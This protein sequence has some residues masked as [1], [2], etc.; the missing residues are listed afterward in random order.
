VGRAVLEVVAVVAEYG[1][2]CFLV[3]QHVAGH[4]KQRAPQNATLASRAW[5]FACCHPEGCLGG[6]G[7]RKHD[8]SRVLCRGTPHEPAVGSQ[9][10]VYELKRAAGLRHGSQTHF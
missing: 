1:K 5:P 10:V 2:H 8:G 9:A 6:W 4:M 7:G 3:T